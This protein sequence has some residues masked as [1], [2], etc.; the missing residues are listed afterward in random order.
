[1]RWQRVAYAVASALAL[2]LTLAA[3]AQMGWTE[4]MGR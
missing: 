2:A 1:M 4:V 3:R